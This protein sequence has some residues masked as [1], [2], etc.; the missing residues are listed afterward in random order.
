MKKLALALLFLTSTT[1]AFAERDSLITYSDKWNLSTKFE[2]GFTEI[3]EQVGPLGGLIIAGHLNDKLGLGVAGH[4]SID[5]TS[6]GSPTLGTIGGGDFWYGGLYTEYVFGSEKLV[7]V[8]LDLLIGG[9]EVTVDRSAG[10][11]ESSSVLTVEPGLNLMVNI[12]ET[13][14][15]GLGASYRFVEDLDI[16]GMEED[17]LS[18]VT[19][20]LFFR[21]T[22]F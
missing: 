10:N 18:G 7:Y 16:P 2:L 20:K 19:G 3:D 4:V 13:F 17:A 1:A 8:S 6:V 22:E 5:E 9:G 14:M 11:S 21:F 12:T 15:F